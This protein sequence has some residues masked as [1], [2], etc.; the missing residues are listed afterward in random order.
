MPGISGFTPADGHCQV[1]ARVERKG[2]PRFAPVAL[3]R[4]MPSGA[5]ASAELRSLAEHEP[6]SRGRVAADGA[7]YR[8]MIAYAGRWI[9]DAAQDKY[10]QV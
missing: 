2:D 9:Y 1:L 6:R 4:R 7:M 3:L 8:H 5:S 10:Y